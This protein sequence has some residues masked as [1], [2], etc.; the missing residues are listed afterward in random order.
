[1]AAAPGWDGRMDCRAPCTLCALA[2]GRGIVRALHGR[3]EHY[4]TSACFLQGG[5]EGFLA[6]RRIVGLLL[7]LTAR[8]SFACGAGKTLFFIRGVGS[9]AHPRMWEAF[10]PTRGKE[11]K[12]DRWQ[13]N[14][15]STMAAPGPLV[16]WLEDGTSCG[17]RLI[18]SSRGRLGTPWGCYVHCLLA[19]GRHRWAAL[20]ARE[21]VGFWLR[22]RS[23]GSLAHP[24]MREAVLSLSRERTKGQPV[25]AKLRQHHG[26]PRT[27]RRLA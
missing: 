19:V 15:D 2:E 5:T 8:D 4:T 7:R 9:L 3:W 11:P 27:P 10:F 16:A 1:M 12:G 13:P 20:V 14:R 25:A 26:C 24:R 6:A 18:A 21:M 23:A 17:A 22:L